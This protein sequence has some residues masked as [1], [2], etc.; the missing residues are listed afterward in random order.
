M[1]FRHLECFVAA[2]EELNFT[3]A[4]AR[5][6]VSQPPFSKQI[7]DLEVELGIELFQRQPKGVSLTAAGRVFLLDAKFILQ[8]SE[9]AIKKAQRISRGEI[10]ELVVGYLPAFT[11]DFLGSALELWRQTAPGVAVD[12]VEMDGAAQETSLLQGLI[13]VGLLLWGER[14][15]LQ[16][17]QVR[18]LLDYPAR[19]ALPRTHPLADRLVL[20]LG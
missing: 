13:D 16:L 18:H 2:A 3:H 12:C 9:E 20:P 10:G 1:K 5:L 17:L 11:Q 6:H 19:V 15:V 4:A 14:P 8:T 7:H